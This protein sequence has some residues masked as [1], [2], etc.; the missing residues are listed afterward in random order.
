MK[1]RTATMDDLNEIANVEVECFPAAE[2]ATKEEFADR[3]R[4]KVGGKS[5]SVIDTDHTDEC[6]LPDYRES[7]DCKDDKNR[8]VAR[9]DNAE[10]AHFCEM[11]GHEIGKQSDD[12][13][14]YPHS[15]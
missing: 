9:L 6:N 10:S 4:Y 7:L 3:I 11:A 13:I 1:I 14:F 12:D 5:V 2:A 8:S 15:F